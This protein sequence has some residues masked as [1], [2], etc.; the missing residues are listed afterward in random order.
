MSATAT[1]TAITLERQPG[2]SQAHDT[3]AWLG[4]GVT[5]HVTGSGRLDVVELSRC[6]GS[7]HLSF[8]LTAAQANALATELMLA[9]YAVEDARGLGA[10]NGR[11]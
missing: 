2:S 1:A 6:D 11:V 10:Q 7:T 8:R 4:D 9:A 3:Y 5:L